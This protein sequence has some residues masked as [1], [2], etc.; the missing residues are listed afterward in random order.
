MAAFKTKLLNFFFHLSG[1][2]FTIK[3]KILES[4][5][6]FRAL[7]YFVLL[8]LVELGSFLVSLPLFF[9]V[10]PKDLQQ[11]GFIFPHDGKKKEHL[12]FFIL[13]RKIGIFTAAGAAA[14]YGLKIFFIGMVSFF[15]LGAQA[16][17]AS[18]QSWVF[19][20]PANF[21]FDSAKIELT[22][23]NAQLKDLGVTFSGATTNAG[24]DSNLTGWNFPNWLQPPSTNATSNRQASGGNPDAYVRIALTASRK[25]LT[26]A[27][28][29][30]QSFVTTVANPATATV[31]LDWS[32]TVFTSPTAPQ[33]YHLYAFVDSANTDPVLGTQVWD[34]GEISATTPWASVSNIDVHT[35]LGAAGTYY[36][37]FAAYA[38][39]NLTTD[40][41]DAYT[42]GFDNVVLN[43]SNTSHV[44]DSGSP[45]ITPTTSLNPAKVLS[46]DSFA[47]TATKNGG[48]INYQLSSDDGV[49]WQYWNGTAW[50]TAG[51]GN[52]NTAAIV[53]TNI[54][55]FTKTTNKIRWKAFLSG[56][57]SQQVIL[58]NV[59]INYTQDNPPVV[60][61]LTPA[62]G[63]STGLVYL[64][65]NLQDPESDVS[66]LN[67]S[68]YSVDGTTWQ[69]M[70]AA[71][72]DP[73]HSGI[74]GLTTSAA[75]VAHTFVWNALADIGSFYNA[76]VLVRLKANDGFLD[77]AV[78]TSSAFAVDYVNPVVANVVATET[79]G[80]TSVQITYDLTDNTTDNLLVELAV[81]GD[82]GVT[83]TV[84]VTS[85]TGAV[86]AAVTAAIGNTITW[87]A[88][89]DYPAHQQSNIQ[90]RV[91]AKDKF[92]N[93]G[94]FVASISF[95][96]DTLAP[97]TNAIANLFAQPN[98]GDSAV[99][100]GGSFT[101]A[102]PST[103]TFSVG[104]SGAD[105]GAGTVGTPNTATPSNQSTVAGTTL[106]GN[107]YISKVKIVHADLYGQSGTNENTSP[108]ATYKYVKPYTP[109]APTLTNPIT[110]NLNLTVVPNASE[111]SGLQY[112]IFETSTSQ[113]VQANGALGAGAIWQTL[114]TGAGQWGNGTGVTGK[115]NVTGLTPH[116]ST[117]IFKVKSRNPNDGGHAAS[118]ESALSSPSQITNTA[119]TVTLGSIAQTT[120]GTKYV[121]INYTGTDGQG[122]INS[123]ASFQYST[124]GGGIWATMTEKSGV[125][126]N[127]TINLVFLP[128]GSNYKFVW[129]SGTDLAGVENS[130]V[131]I[132][133]KSNDS[134]L[135]SAVATS[136]AFA[137]DNVVPVTAV[138]SASMSDTSTTVTVVYTLTDGNNSNVQMDVSADGGS[139][140]TVPHASATGAIGA[141]IT[142]GAGK[143]ITWNVA[144]D[145]DGEYTT[146][147]MVRVRATDTF[148]NQGV[149]SSSSA[150]E[151]DTKAPVVSNVTAVQDAVAKTFTFHYDV[152]EDNGN[153]DTALAISSDG[154]S[155]WVV[156]ITSAAGAFGAATV[157]GA[158]K[159]I[160]WNAGTDFDNQEHADMKIKITATDKH[161]NVSN[162]TSSAFSL[163]TKAPR[164]TT[165]AGTQPLGGTTVN[166]TYDLA[167]QNN[168]TVQLQIS[169]NGGSSWVVP[170]TSA[171]GALGASVASGTGKTI[172]WNAA[173]DFPNQTLGTMQV[174]IQA[175]D[176]FNNASGDVD[177]TNFAL[178]TLAPAVNA[179]AELQTQ[180][181]A[182]DTIALIGGSFTEANPSTNAFYVAVDVGSYGSSTAGTTNTATPTNQATATGVTLKGNDYISKVKITHTDKY[183]QSITNENT[184]P[185]AALKYVKPYTPALPTVDNPGVGTVDVTVNKNPAEADSL[186][187]AI[188]E[189]TLSEY[190][191]GNG[192]IGASPVWQTLGT[193]S[194]QWG[195][196]SGV[197]G[198]VN[199][200]GLTRHSYTYGFEV[201]SR[202]PSDTGFAPSSESALSSGASSANQ[203]PHITF[204]S[205]SQSTDGSKIVDIS[206]NGIDLESETS[207]L[208]Q[209]K[210]STDNSTWTTMTEKSGVGSE[211]VTGLAFSDSGV[212]HHFKWDVGTDL[213][214][215]EDATVYVRLQ[216]ND[217]HTS[218]AAAVSSS[219]TIDTKKPVISA[220]T[221][222]ML[223]NG[224]GTVTI[225]YTLG[226]VSVSNVELNISANDGGDWVVPITTASGDINAGVV[227]GSGKTITWNAGTD[228]AN[229]EV[230]IM[231]LRLKATDSYSNAGD[232]TVSGN[233]EVDTK[234]PV[235]SNVT[236]SQN[237]GAGT[238]AIA[239]DLVDAN[240]STV[241][242][243]VSNDNG[244]TWIVPVT[245]ATGAVGTG[246]TPAVNKTVTWNAAT[247]YPNHEQNLLIKVSATDQFGNAGVSTPSSFAVDT[248][249]PVITNIGA[250]QT[251]GS[252]NFVITYDLAD[253]ATSAIAMDI[254]DNS[255]STW[256]V[257]H[258][259]AAGDLGAAVP[260]G[261]GKTIT[262]NAGTD[263]TNHQKSTMMVRL[264]GT[265]GFNN[266]SDNVSSTAFNLDTLAP[267]TNAAA[268]LSTQPNAGDTTALIEG[269]FTESNPGTNDFALALNGLAYGASTAGTGNTATPPAQATAAGQTLT[270][271]D[272]VSKVKITEGDLYGKTA[273]NENTAPSTTKK[274]VK[275][276]KPDAPTVGNPQ[277]TSVD[278]TVNPHTGESSTVPYAIFETTTGKY[279]Q[280]NGSLD[281]AAV[282]KTL[283]TAAGQWG[284][285]SGVSGK[286]TVTGLTSPVARYS[287]EVKSRNPADTAH[288]SGSESSF[289]NVGAVAN[290]APVISIT[291]VAQPLNRSYVLVNYSGT[292][293][294]NDTNDLTSYEYSTDN[295]IW[296]TMTQKAGVGADGISGLAF[297]SSGHSFVFAW[298]LAADLANFGSSTVYVRLQANDGL[299]SG[300]L[301]TSSAF[302]VD[303]L[304]PVISN[305]NIGQIPGT[306]GLT[307]HYDMVDNSGTNNSVEALISDDS[308]ATYT[309]ATTSMAGDVG[310]GI[311]IGTNK[312]ITWNAG[313]DF[314]NQES[315]TMKI[316]IRG[317]DAYD[318]IGTFVA[319]DD[320]SVDTKLPVVSGVTAAQTAGTDNVEVNYT[321]ADNTPA[322]FL[323][324]AEFSADG[325]TTWAV[326]AT[327]VTGAIGTGIT[328]GAKTFTW[329]AGTD[330]SAQH[331]TNMK[332]RVKAKDYFGNQGVFANSADF[333]IDTKAPVVSAL[334]ATQTLGANNAVSIAYDLADD[335]SSNITVTPEI[336]KN[337][338]TT[339]TVAT[340]TLAGNFGS[341]QTAGAG[342]AISWNPAVDLATTEIANARVRLQATDSFGNSSVFESTDFAVDTLA[343]V[344]LTS[345]TKFSSTTTAATLNWAG[346]V[347][348]SNFDHY[349][350]WHGTS[351]TDVDARIGTA[352]KWSTT[353]DPTLSD[354]LTSITTITGIPLT[355]NYF[356]KIWAVDK[357]GNEATVVSINLFEVPA[358][359]P[360]PVVSGG[361]GTPAVLFNASLL[362]VPVLDRLATPTNKTSVNVSGVAVSNAKIILYDN[363]TFVD[364]FTALA[365]ANGRFG[366]TFTFTEG[367]HILT[368]KAVDSFNNPSANSNGMPLLIDL[369][370]PGLPSVANPAENENISTDTP[371]LNGFAE[372]YS[373]VQITV[374]KK[375]K[376]TTATNEIGNWTFNLPSGA[377]L[378]LG[379]HQFELVVVDP[380]GNASAV[381]LL[382][383]NRVVAPAGLTG[384]AAV[385]GPAL[386]GAA[387]PTGGATT[388][389]GG[390]AP[391]APLPIP[392]IVTIG[393]AAEATVLPNIPQPQIV[394]IQN[395]A[396]TETSTANV[397]K[398]SGRALPNQE[399]VLYLHSDQALVYRVKADGNGIWNLDHLQ[400]NVELTPGEHS[401]FAVALDPIAKVKSLPSA[402]KTFTVNKNFWVMAY[403]YLNLYSTLITVVVILVGMFLLYRMRK[404]FKS[405]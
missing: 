366:Q 277:N 183:G 212:L 13:R 79:L 341:G 111:A 229:Q 217:G 357:Y 387:R 59:S 52:Y 39:N 186:E 69:T 115:V 282:W 290:T 170:T 44:Y 291:S 377:T 24:F 391:G 295:S 71:T 3:K 252:Q 284:N 332:V 376:F 91:R 56:N 386:P 119:P 297:T 162:T 308:G 200:S 299:T 94:V 202:N 333:A 192:T 166:I 203:S 372:P 355:N 77:S 182:G 145:Y 129:D 138:T 36:L 346:S 76:T 214:N 62:Q 274:Y 93:Q 374:D 261:N 324:E 220:I 142:P 242:I 99:L 175:T 121:N 154:G 113:Y 205:I 123:L 156:P 331:K 65:Y 43:W 330:F 303:T 164:V 238:I 343:P 88:G 16:L 404:K 185:S 247:D 293:A 134:L 327:T 268:D 306:D 38:T 288:Q 105:Y 349:E 210:Y 353:E 147:M 275:P 321:L 90:V 392:A 323:V 150:F 163:D 63:T 260:A 173:A 31:S 320:F 253:S 151:A 378:A 11:L 109:Q 171:T 208:V 337:G 369:T 307:I 292:D 140:W 98:A 197:S 97:A 309:V 245:S 289:S 45:T 48:E 23:G 251:L 130:S 360:T 103:N 248:K 280:T 58:N 161:I 198:K 225:H 329:D 379:K 84:P 206:Y 294:Q 190:V 86:G 149:N 345:L 222:G 144:S 191:Q 168:S 178:D 273:T 381:N 296:H 318:N 5:G 267:A 272:Y 87:N 53:N 1:F 218:G 41:S 125:G 82:S 117:F 281:T 50:A 266:V 29:R 28:Y 385:G 141:G 279:V 118:S 310:S 278:V 6:V 398:F 30:R 405:A 131:L 249:G 172:T 68:E 382:D 227:P 92:L 302:S 81:S 347:T 26:V 356:V 120:D 358:P 181:S 66:N 228:F 363:G 233:F 136:S 10:S 2:I 311:S 362:N 61:S 350:L 359:T 8:F 380:A 133:L 47:E 384:A 389:V 78:A 298:D 263:Y 402:I 213:A 112:A 116:I 127:S 57:G 335:A 64:P 12:H 301:A 179:A 106:K 397:I 232:F 199:V 367:Q 224:S 122:D 393:Q 4:K 135:D 300:N 364:Y 403:Y 107:D 371:T 373:T 15:I 124:N 375:T 264:R 336:S 174:R 176:I 338:G 219:F 152:S 51:A 319:S 18:T 100:I 167:D 102:N 255:G 165:V 46:W 17:F 209:Y 221:A 237:A 239:Y 9:I 354:V 348:E 286:I 75:G 143:T 226:D 285:S 33:T 334:I 187:Y 194:G 54:A 240:N 370:P 216:A 21:T 110:N 316:K 396:T 304:G 155:T 137:I 74:T 231:K 257:A 283:G 322:G 317:T 236:A 287:F 193:G 313:I 305:I 35:K 246:V 207:S 328:T 401:I 196:G 177:S 339:W 72:S 55:T 400:S 250:V 32:S 188:F 20:T 195:N 159:T 139:T 49:T 101:E 70:T 160:T 265:D 234:A 342:K 7:P 269:S 114:G 153:V 388:L 314:A 243:S 83:W 326:P 22:G 271:S 315:T 259:T 14:L 148:G 201:K 85:A 60:A 128:T 211:G 169:S 351:Q 104:V 230:S 390:I 37:K 262:W 241:S 276:Y 146:Q 215:A 95:A 325:G 340:S 67:A 180:P 383:V 40:E 395:G 184:S 73:A 365:D 368:V 223:T 258:I 352:T 312:N 96:L 89:T 394:S 344:G 34:S 157:P 108:S 80:T 256:V 19:T 189:A 254:S 158:G 126:S 132:R 235:V 204:N 244:V 42:S 270:G 361:G 25:N 27:G 399:V